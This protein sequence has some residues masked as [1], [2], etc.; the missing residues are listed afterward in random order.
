MLLLI[1]FVFGYSLF[2]RMSS[3]AF[4]VAT[5][6]FTKQHNAKL[7]EKKYRELEDEGIIVRRSAFD[8]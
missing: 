6:K 2:A 7:R 3:H 8:R 4:R 1:S 5:A